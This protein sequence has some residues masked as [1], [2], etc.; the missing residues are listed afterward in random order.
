MSAQ[1]TAQK[2]APKKLTPLW[3]VSLFVS[4][5]E[6][7]LG[8][9]ATQTS[10][11]TQHAL[12]IF[13]LVFPILIAGAFFTF[14]WHRPWVFYSPSEYGNVDVRGFVEAIKGVS[15][16]IVQETKD[17]QGP[18]D[19]VGNP[20][21]LKL[22][23][24]AAGKT[25]VRSTKAMEVGDGCVV[26]VSTKFLT[27]QGAWNLAEAVTYVPGAEIIEEAGGSGRYLR[28]PESGTSKT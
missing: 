2:Q 16:P 21:R 11:G 28:M 17:V 8:I 14:L 4:L 10:G 23:F 15:G 24:K 3:V 9:A 13:V 18:V 22:L 25:W 1:G 19:I 27:P 26:Q 6:V 12:V 7:T 20:D 5:T